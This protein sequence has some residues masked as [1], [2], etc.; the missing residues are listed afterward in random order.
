MFMVHSDELAPI[1]CTNS[2]FQSYMDSRQSTSNFVFTLGGATVIQKSV[3]QSCIVNSTM[4][5]KYIATFEVEKEVIWLRKF[6]M[7]LRVVSLL[8]LPMTLFYDNNGVVTQSK[9]LKHH[10]KGKNI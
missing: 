2:D 4:E 1:R 9:E 8:I 5:A 7:R 10:R 6:L 3:K